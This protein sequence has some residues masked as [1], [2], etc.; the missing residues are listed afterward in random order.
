MERHVTPHSESGYEKKHVSMKKNVANGK[1]SVNNRKMSE[2]KLYRKEQRKNEKTGEVEDFLL[3]STDQPK[4]D[5]PEWAKLFASCTEQFM[6]DFANST[7][8]V[9]MYFVNELLKRPH[10]GETA[11]VIILSHGYKKIAKK[12][13]LSNRSVADKVRWLVK[14]GYL[15]KPHPRQYVFMIPGKF[16]ARG[17]LKK[18]EQMQLTFEYE[19][20]TGDTDD[21][22]QLEVLDE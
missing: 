9:Y 19:E 17:E 11:Q 3:L 16:M 4:P 14:K 13:K 18:V 10:I 12:L 6:H 15:L 22:E 21:N 20:L 5:E 7:F 1:K 2:K 8:G